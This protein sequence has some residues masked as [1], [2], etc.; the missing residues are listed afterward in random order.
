MKTVVNKVFDI[1]TFGLYVRLLLEINQFF[2]ISGMN[3]LYY[4]DVSGG[5]RIASFVFAIIVLL[6]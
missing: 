6:F 2:L 1:M 3:E 5:L 4:G